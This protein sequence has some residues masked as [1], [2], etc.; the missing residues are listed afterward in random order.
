MLSPRQ[1][2]KLKKLLELSLDNVPF[3]RS[4]G[5]NATHELESFPIISKKDI[6]ANPESFLNTY[7]IENEEQIFVENTSGTSGE[8]LKVYK[9]Y[10][11]RN[12]NAK[13]IWTLRN[14]WYGIKPQDVFYKF[15]GFTLI[16]GVPEAGEIIYEQNSIEFSVMD[17]SE[18][19]MARYVCELQKG[20]GNWIFA[21]PSA[22]YMLSLFIL[23]KRIKDIGNI[24]Y[25]ELAGER[26]FDYQVDIIRQAFNC[27][28]GNQYGSREV[29]GI[30][31]RCLYGI[32]HI[33]DDNVILES[34]D[35]SG[36][37]QCGA[38]GEL[39]VTSLNNYY[40][41]FIRYKLGDI[42]VVNWIEECNCG[43]RG[44]VLEQVEGRLSE[45]V[46]IDDKKVSMMWFYYIAIRFN[47]MFNNTILHFQIVQED[48]KQFRYLVVLRDSSLEATLQ[49]FFQQEANKM[50]DDVIIKLSL[51]EKIEF[52][53]NKYNHFVKKF[54][55]G[56]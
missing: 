5:K 53:G 33:I 23:D 8:P 34:I 20:K 3:Y 16:N 30:A 9:T 38:P 18:A 28:I 7:L 49:V 19:S 48:I 21:L 45:Y 13:T 40:M 51:I 56:D 26:H 24:K 44:Q 36:I 2:Y 6:I 43:T 14:K 55:R 1:K 35:E 15:G 42:G 17:M 4:L 52:L 50:F 12:V 29:W 25:I 39:V 41:P 11:E 10:S 22:I 47:A 46:D 31:Q 37:S 27:A 32:N 54:N